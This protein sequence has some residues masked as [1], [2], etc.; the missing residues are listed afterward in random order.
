MWTISLQCILLV[1]LA[2][3]SYSSTVMSSPMMPDHGGSHDDHAA[4]PSVASA[5]DAAAFTNAGHNHANCHD[6][7]M[8]NS[9][10]VRTLVKRGLFD[11]LMP[12]VPGAPIASQ[13]A[14]AGG[15]DFL[16]NFA[17]QAQQVLATQQLLQS[18]QS[19]LS[20]GPNGAASQAMAAPQQAMQ[21][22][23]AT[24]ARALEGA[25]QT[26]QAGQTGIRAALTELGQGLQRLTQTNPNLVPE[27]K[28]IYQR[29]SST[30]SS[31]SPS[32]PNPNN[33]LNITPAKNSEQL[34]DNLGKVIGIQPAQ[35]QPLYPNLM[36]GI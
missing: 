17:N 11:G 23:Q 14:P 22:A 34:A 9:N 10:N 3:S 33:P 12:P 15:Q 8:A 35:P 28:S 13:Q 19:L 16:S 20:G 24:S 4:K 25:A 18:A 30:L 6:S 32:A 27:V 26:A 2:M 29:V 21:T 31:A 5:P 1:T 7:A 36:G